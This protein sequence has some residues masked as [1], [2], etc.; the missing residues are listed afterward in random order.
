[1]ILNPRCRALIRQIL[2][3]KRAADEVTPE[4]VADIAKGIY[5]A[6]SRPELRDSLSSFIRNNFL[7]APS[8]TFVNFIGNLASLIGAP[9]TRFTRGKFSEAGSMLVGY[10]KA[11]AEVFP[12]M[13]GGYK[14]K[15][16]VFDGR[17]SKEFDFYLKLPGQKASKELD[18][19]NKPINAVVTLPQSI[20]RGID[21]GFATFFERAQFEIFMDQ[22]KKAPKEDILK[23]YGITREELGDALN[24]AVL[25]KSKGGLRDVRS[26]RIFEAVAKIDPQAAKL[27][28]EFAL[29]GTFRSPLGDSIIDRGARSWF[30]LSKTK[31]GGGSILA[32]LQ[33]LTTPF[34]IT[35]L[36]V[37]KFGATFVPG[38]GLARVRQA[39]KDID[40]LKI[41]RQLLND[42][43]LNAKNDVTKENLHRK[44]LE[45][46]GQIAF[47]QQLKND[48]ISQQMLGLGFSG[49]AFG[50]VEAGMLTGDYP[51]DPARRARMTEAGIPPNS[52]KVGDRWISYKGIEP[53]HTVFTIFANGKQK[54]EELALKGEADLSFSTG[55][56]VA[57]VVKNA[58]LDK[59]FTAQLADLM[60]AVTSEDENKASALVARATNGL[61]PNFLNWLAKLEDP[62]KRE[63]KDK[64]LSTW[65]LNNIKSRIP[66]LR[67]ELAPVYSSITGETQSLGTPGEI[68]TGFRFAE[69]NRNKIQKL[70]DN[71]ELNIAPPSSDLYGIKLTREQY[72]RMSKIMGDYTNQTLDIL[73][74]SEGFMLLPKSLQAKGIKDAVNQ[75][76]SDVRKM[77]LGE[78]I[79]DH[80]S[81]NYIKF[82][83]NEFK[84]KGLNPY[85]NPD[86]IIE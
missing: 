69:V 7:S 49:W 24:K 70:F 40:K 5:E 36:N 21:E 9:I 86:I 15:Q 45:L 37:A 50:M 52:I 55:A 79:Q 64:D 83:Q 59:T 42:K 31:E 26:E 18:T 1:M 38:I 46:D 8:T 32:P 84:K 66:G 76:R 48:F 65:M 19:I 71:P 44:L 12:R 23:R 14:N 43:W 17:T 73:A 35:P 62:I 6:S 22:L 25:S 34:I 4:V 39:A 80:T 75:I 56:Q 85:T 60:N 16:I 47:K 58:F 61:T 41:K 2:E 67:E 81:P 11:F 13:I 57:S 53:I 20:Q 29:Y 10:T 3:G 54:I 27:I 77:I 78:L 33:A 63:V 28:E 74:S 82:M 51:A 72:S 30:N 68:T